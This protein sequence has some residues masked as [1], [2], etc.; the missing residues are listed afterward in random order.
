MLD[1]KTMRAIGGLLARQARARAR[2]ADAGVN[3]VIDWGR[4][5][6]NGKPGRLKW[7]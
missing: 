1:L 3:E 5:W 7:R 6:R 4:C 2:E